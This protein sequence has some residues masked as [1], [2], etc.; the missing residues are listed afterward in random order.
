MQTTWCHVLKLLQVCSYD[1]NLV[2]PGI[3]DTVPRRDRSKPKVLSISA[4]VSI[5]ATLLPEWTRK[6]DKRAHKD[7]SDRFIVAESRR[8][9]AVLVTC[10]RLIIDY[11]RKGHVLVFDARL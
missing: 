9:N 3:G 1:Y 11:A 4:S 8:R 5:E 10:D 7:P 6:S 2:I